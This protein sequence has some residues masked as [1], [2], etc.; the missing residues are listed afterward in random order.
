[1]RK[2]KEQQAPAMAELDILRCSPCLASLH[3]PKP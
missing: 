3:Y 1:M 2:E